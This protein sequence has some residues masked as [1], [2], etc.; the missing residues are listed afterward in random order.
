MPERLDSPVQTCLNPAATDEACLSPPPL[1][2]ASMNEASLPSHVAAEFVE[3]TNEQPEHDI[4]SQSQAYPNDARPELERKLMKFTY[5]D[6]VK[7]PLAEISCGSASTGQTQTYIFCDDEDQAVEL[8]RRAAC[9]DEPKVDEVLL[10]EEL[11]SDEDEE[12]FQRRLQQEVMNHLLRQQEP[13]RQ[14]CHRIKPTSVLEFVKDLRSDTGSDPNDDCTKGNELRHSNFAD[15]LGFEEQFTRKA[16]GSLSSP[17]LLSTEPRMQHKSQKLRKVHQS[18]NFNEYVAKRE[19]G[20][21]SRKHGGFKHVGRPDDELEPIELIWDVNMPMLQDHAGRIVSFFVPPVV[22]LPV[23]FLVRVFVLWPVFFIMRAS[24]FTVKVLVLVWSIVKGLIKTGLFF[25]H[26]L[27]LRILQYTEGFAYSVFGYFDLLKNQ[28]VEL[29]WSFKELGALLIEGIQDRFS[30]RRRRRRHF[31]RVLVLRLL[32][33]WDVILDSFES[34]GRLIYLL[35]LPA[36]VIYQALQSCA[37]ATNITLSGFW[38]I[39]MRVGS[40][41]INSPYIFGRQGKRTVKFF[42]K[43]RKDVADVLIALGFL[44]ILGMIISGTFIPFLRSILHIFGAI[45]ELLFGRL[46]KLQLPRL[47]L[48][49]FNMAKLKDAMPFSLPKLPMPDFGLLFG[50]RERTFM[51][52]VAYAF[53]S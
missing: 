7:Q 18:K 22:Y 38:G 26:Q 47:R 37:T 39:P 2:E 31:R 34:L 19:K 17:T 51:E 12:A 48:P 28:I 6:E 29:Y 36:R 32:R 5:A 23:M 4:Q 9:G 14:D 49:R 13:V 15:N 42:R 20:G 46:T 44:L 45:L 40:F 33:L 43:N 3:A 25:P 50:L 8:L 1:N 27:A 35:F 10:I 30:R 52:K 53:F 24:R 41:V 16:P 21:K 11:S